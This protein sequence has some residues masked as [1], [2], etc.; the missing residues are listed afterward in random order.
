MSAP[1]I[2]RRPTLILFSGFTLG[3]GPMLLKKT[4]LG[5]IAPRPRPHERLKRGL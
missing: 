1:V 3:L 5:L 4:S 2:A